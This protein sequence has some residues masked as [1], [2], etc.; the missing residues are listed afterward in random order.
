MKPIFLANFLS[1]RLITLFLSLSFL[2]FS[3]ATMAFTDTDGKTTTIENYLGKGK[4]TVVEVWAT[5]CPACR[6]HMPSMVKFDG[7]LKNTQILGV[8]LDGQAGADKVD[9]FIMEYG[10]KFPNLISNAIEMNIWMQQNTPEGLIGTPAFM[11]FNP[12]GQLL[13]MQAGMIKVEQ[14]ERLIKERSQASVATE[15]KG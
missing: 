7:K 1:K 10:M 15:K 8:S 3:N 5:D 4:F 2:A 11:I 9:D 13:A 14:I 6:K 12:K